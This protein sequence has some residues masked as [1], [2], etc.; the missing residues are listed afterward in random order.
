MKNQL[1]RWQELAGMN[2]TKVQS[3]NESKD[4]QP[5]NKTEPTTTLLEDIETNL[6]NRNLLKEQEQTG[7]VTPISVELANMVPAANNFTT[8]T[9]ALRLM[10][11]AIDESGGKFRPSVKKVVDDARNI[12]STIPNFQE[13][14]PKDEM[15][16]NAIM[17]AKSLDKF[18][19]L[20]IKN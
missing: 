13:V 6:K 17:T 12:N 1:E 20:P 4:T 8:Y 11:D 18:S 3:I 15:L 16:K 9:N 7:S 5:V 2:K 14:K 10:A 19:S